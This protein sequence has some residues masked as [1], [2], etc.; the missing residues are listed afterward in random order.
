[1]R[2]WILR[3]TGFL[4]FAGLVAWALFPEGYV[5]RGPLL[6]RML[7]RDPAVPTHEI[8]DLRLQAPPGYE[9][10][11]WAEDLGDARFMRFSPDGSLLLAQSRLGQVVHVLGDRDGDGFS[12]GQRVLVANL[13]RPHG[14]DFR[15]DPGIPILVEV[16][17]AGLPDRLFTHDVAF[18][19]GDVA[20]FSVTATDFDTPPVSFS[21]EFEGP[22]QSITFGDNLLCHD[23][24]DE[25]GERVTISI[26][27]SAV[28]THLDHGDII[29]V[30][31]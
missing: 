17:E 19:T 18:E 28:A 4:L 31:P 7:G 9:V 29:G 30:C 23:P 11:L 27:D 3:I 2:R 8:V 24:D 13:D 21:K 14:I 22:V 25:L 1:M 20:L 5:V 12:D 16:F 6:D 26:G 10:T 15:D